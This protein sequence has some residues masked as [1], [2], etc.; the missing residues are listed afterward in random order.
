[1]SIPD[2]HRE[3]LAGTPFGD[4]IERIFHKDIALYE[5]VGS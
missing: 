4:L 1:L 2:V 3:L 5:S